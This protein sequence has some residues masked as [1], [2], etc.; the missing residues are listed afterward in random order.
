[1]NRSETA[2]LLTAMAAFDRRTLG[3]ADVIAWQVL[4]ADVNLQDGLEAV[5]RW[6]A[7]HTEWMMPAHV[8][9]LVRDIVNERDMAARA[10]GWAPGQAG[11]PKDHPMPELKPSAPYERLT[12]ET[13]A[14]PV[15]ELLETLGV[16]LRPG[17]R[18]VLM[19]RRM[20]WEKEHAAYQRAQGAEPN[21]YYRPG[22][23]GFAADEVV[24]DEVVPDDPA[25]PEVCGAALHNG[26]CGLRAGHPVGPWLPGINGHMAVDE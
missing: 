2:Q 4:M 15:R 19:P 8:R 16:K 22:G 14:A 3:D 26:A 12:E 21:P 7:E 10:T 13:L 6:Y 24:I 18:A 25:A 1:M 11:V 5:Q 9:R 20:F 23:R 17:S